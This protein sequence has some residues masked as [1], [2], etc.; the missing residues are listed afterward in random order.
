M[1]TIEER[2]VATEERCKS[3]GHRIG[4]LEDVTATLQKLATS[5]E[6]MAQS[7]GQMAK[8]LADQGER[9]ELLEREPAERWNTM[10]RTIFTSAIST[11]AGGAVGAL[12]TL[13][14]K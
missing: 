3:N 9:L 5:V 4:K 14:I 13:F 8:E 7:V 6:L 2:L 1:S 11:L 12:V 10:R